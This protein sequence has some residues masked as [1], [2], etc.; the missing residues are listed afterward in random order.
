MAEYAR[1]FNLRHP[2][3]MAVSLFHLLEKFARDPVRDGYLEAS[4]KNWESRERDFITPSGKPE[5][6]KSMNTHLHILEAY[7]NLYR[8]YPEKEVG[9]RIAAVLGFFRDHI[10]D[11]SNRHFRMF[12]DLE[13]QPKTTAI[14]YGHDIE[15]TWLLHEAAEVLHNSVEMEKTE[16][17]ILKMAAAV[18][19]E[20]VDPSGGLYNESDGEHW[21]KNFH[22]WPQAEAVVGFFN[23]WQLTKE[24][25][26]LNWSVNAW[27]FIQKYQIDHK[28]GEW[29]GL[30][31]PDYKVRPMDKVSPWKCPYHNGRMCMEMIRR[32]NTL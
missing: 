13:W 19:N 27:K 2:E 18:G 32:I 20:A 9:D 12:F 26:F 15:G 24:E 25:K 23:A 28:N 22:W 3:E 14:S 30:I 31:T 1:I 16:P 5:I 29:F 6:R 17:V 7:T 8:I 21:D 10:I 4:V 11:P